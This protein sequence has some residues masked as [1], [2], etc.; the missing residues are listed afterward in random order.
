MQG[1]FQ[2]FFS[3]YRPLVNQLNELL[4]EY[5]LSYSLWQVIVYLKNNGKSSLV[6]IAGYYNIEKPSITRR[7]HALEK[8]LLIQETADGK[9]QRKKVIQLTDKAEDLYKICRERITELEYMAIIGLTKEEQLAVYTALPKIQLNII[10]G[11][12]L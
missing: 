11:K 6:D 8:M 4:G 7:V 3:L 1:F 12:D 2:R 9:D 5:D 10:N